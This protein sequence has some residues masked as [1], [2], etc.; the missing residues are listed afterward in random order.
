MD[1]QPPIA[2]QDMP[3]ASQRHSLRIPLRGTALIPVTIIKGAVA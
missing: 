1:P 3:T 2:H